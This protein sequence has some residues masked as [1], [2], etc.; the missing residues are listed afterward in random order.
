MTHDRALGEVEQL[1]LFALV[2][3]GDEAYGVTVRDLIESE[4]GRALSPGAVFTGYE[5]LERR[6]LVLSRLGPATPT[7]GGRPKR[8]YSLSARGA[9]ALRDSYR[10]VSSL[11]R[12]SRLARLETLTR[13]GIK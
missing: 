7:R 6:G 11:A 12:R 4:T 1:L 3:L 8:H 5:R 13:K 2:A 10:R 9:L